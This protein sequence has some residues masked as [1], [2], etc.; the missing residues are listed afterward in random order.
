MEIWIDALRRLPDQ[1]RCQVAGSGTNIGQPV[2]GEEVF[3]EQQKRLLETDLMDLDVQ[4]EVLT[5][6]LKR[7]GII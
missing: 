3:G 7:E 4:I 2:E 1:L 6:Q 5:K